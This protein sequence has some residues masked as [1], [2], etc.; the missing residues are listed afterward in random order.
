MFVFTSQQAQ[1]VELE[2]GT[3]L[4]NLSSV[5]AFQPV[6]IFALLEKSLSANIILGL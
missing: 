1:R 5:L 6:I 3:I 4:D 2:K